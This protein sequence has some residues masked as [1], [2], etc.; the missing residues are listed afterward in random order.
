MVSDGYGAPLCILFQNLIKHK[1]ADMEISLYLMSW[2]Y[3]N[4]GLV[5]IS[6]KC[7]TS[8][9]VKGAVFQDGAGEPRALENDW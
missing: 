1:I 7:C 5:L 3:I 8:L 6:L 2:R 9:F 4:S